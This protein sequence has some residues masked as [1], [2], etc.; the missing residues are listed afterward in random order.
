MSKFI[1][2]DLDPQ[3]IFAVGGSSRGGHAK[4]DGAFAWDGT[5]GEPPPALTA[6]TAARLGEKVRERLGAAGISTAPAL[7]TIPRDRVILKELRYPTVPP[8]EEPNVVR[9]QALKELTDAAD[10]V[11]LDYVPLSNG[12]PE[13]ERR[14]MAFVVRKEYFAA[15]QAFCTAA[16]L[17]L[18][19]VT[20]RPYCVAA[21][22]ADAM[23]A[24][25]V[26]K[27]EGPEPIAVVTLGPGGGEF[28]VVRPGATIGSGEVL[29]TRTISAA[30]SSSEA[31]GLAEV[32]RNLTMYAGSN[33]G[34]PVQALYI[35]D[36]EGRWANRLRNALG[37][38]V[39]AYNPLAGVT[40]T[41]PESSFGRFAGAVGLLAMS[42]LSELPINFVAPRQPKAEKKPVQ[43]KVV[44][45]V[46]GSLV[47]LVTGIAFG[48][49]VVDNRQ[50]ELAALA[51]QK[52]ELENEAKELDPDFK[53]IQAV[54]QW[55]SRQ[56]V[57]LDMLYD[58]T[59][60]F[61]HSDGMVALS[62]AAKAVPPDAKTAKQDAQA[63]VD[64]RLTSRSPDPVNA[65]VTSMESDN[66]EK[67]RDPKAKNQPA[68]KYYLSITRQ[69]G[70]PPAG[71]PAAKEYTIHARVTN[72]E[73]ASFTRM[74]S[75][76]PL[77][78]K[79]YPPTPPKPPANTGPKKDDAETVE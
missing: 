47:L 9:F 20:P 43:T 15:I 46:V 8:T 6:E 54:K 64:I 50:Q 74:A 2:I 58:V 68:P 17:K 16:N 62:Y 22:L 21:G 39:H 5:D 57:W 55:Q 67:N 36:S 19:A 71:D 40:T 52:V 4:V 1:A 44:L 7:V 45:A 18:T 69:I 61:K 23:G 70:G 76:P 79:N 35:A 49:I 32:R 26:A 31:M 41:T 33:P 24:G 13:G 72:R 75:F 11:I 14:S 51:L 38:A 25:A 27:P 59:D 60:Q 30:A 29:F 48:M 12:A 78:R 65:L 37:I 34:H 77:S 73:P 66:P 56:V 63:V 53:R 10:D 42:S 3:G 28:T